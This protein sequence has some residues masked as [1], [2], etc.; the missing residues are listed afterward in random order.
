MRAAF[1]G[2]AVA[3]GRRFDEGFS[4]VQRAQFVH[5]AVVGGDDKFARIHFFG[6]FQNGRGRANRVRQRH[7]VNRRLRVYQHFRAGVLFHQRLQLKGLELVMHDARAVPH[8]HV[9][10]GLA[11]DVAAQ[12]PVGCPEDFLALVFQRTH[13]V[14]RAARCH[15]PVG[16]RLDGGAGVG[17]H[18]HRTVGM[19]VAKGAELIYRAAQVKR[20]GGVQ[21]GH[22]HALFGRQDFG[23]FAHETHARHHQRLRRMVAA[24]TRHFQRIADNAAGF[25]GQVLQIWMHVVVRHHDGVLFFQQATNL[26]FQ[27]RPL[28]LCRLDRHARPGVLGGAMG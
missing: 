9:G 12:M 18:H 10:T 8:H 13:D 1:A 6:G 16:P 23:G 26:V 4:G 5:H 15:N 3:G 28:G 24:K 19:R 7:H 25:F 22:Q 2:G 27:R 20:A 14:Q 17:I 11:L 21:V